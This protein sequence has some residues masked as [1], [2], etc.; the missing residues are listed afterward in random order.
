M[1]AGRTTDYFPLVSQFLGTGTPSVGHSPASR[2][3]VFRSRLHSLPRNSGVVQ[4][5]TDMEMSEVPC[6]ELHS[7][8]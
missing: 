3:V 1:L 2:I 8:Q 6:T 7:A 4:A 5:S